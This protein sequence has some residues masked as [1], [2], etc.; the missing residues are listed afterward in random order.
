MVIRKAL[1]IRRTDHRP[2]M[3]MRRQEVAAIEKQRSVENEVVRHPVRIRF[4]IIACCKEVAPTRLEGR[5]RGSDGQWNCLS[6]ESGPR[7]HIHTI[8]FDNPTDALG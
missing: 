3:A 6:Y 8:A 1:E 7:R 5:I 2:D 4:G